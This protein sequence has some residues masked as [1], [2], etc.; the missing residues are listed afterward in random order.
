VIATN[1][2][3]ES[4]ITALVTVNGNPV[5]GANVTFA[6]NASNLSSSWAVTNASGAAWVYLNASMSPTVA[7]V[8]AI[9]INTLNWTTVRITNLYVTTDKLS[10]SPNETVHISGFLR[11]LNGTP[12]QGG[13][14]TINITAPNGTVWSVDST[15][16]DSEGWFTYDFEL[17]NSAPGT[18]TIMA[19]YED[20]VE[21]CTFTVV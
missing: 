13:I 8:T 16:T 20:Y 10:Y 11:H 6:T 7:N 21:I 14:V 17:G 1:S 2:T 4:K 18:Y 5:V 15:I 9:W 19:K 3:M 12:I